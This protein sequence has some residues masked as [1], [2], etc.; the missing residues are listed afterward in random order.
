LDAAVLD[1]NLATEK[2]Y[3]IA[4]VLAERSIPFLFLTGYV[5]PDM[6]TNL[7]H[8]PILSKPIDGAA[9]VSLLGGLLTQ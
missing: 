4:Y 7:K 6:P 5:T 3:P 8:R 9:L 2:S 1:V